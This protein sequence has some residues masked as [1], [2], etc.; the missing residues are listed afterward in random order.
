MRFSLLL[1][2]VM[3]AV[4]V[5]VTESKHLL[6]R[7]AAKKLGPALIAGGAAGAAL[8]LGAGIISAK[9]H[10]KD[11]GWEQGWESHGWDEGWAPAHGWES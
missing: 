2:F 11:H 4:I 7:V 9:H 5:S 6:L 1:A 8:G 3:M 10:K